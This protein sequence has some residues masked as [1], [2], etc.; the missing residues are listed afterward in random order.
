MLQISYVGDASCAVLHLQVGKLGLNFHCT[1][2]ENSPSGHNDLT[3]DT[4]EESLAEKEEC[5][6][7]VITSDS[8]CQETTKDSMLESGASATPSDKANL[9]TQTEPA[10][11]NAILQ[12]TD[13]V[14]EVE[15]SVTED[16]EKASAE[17]E[18]VKR[19]CS[20]GDSEEPGSNSEAVICD[21]TVSPT[22]GSEDK[23]DGDGNIDTT[24]TTDNCATSKVTG[25]PVPP[26]P[27]YNWQDI[28]SGFM[29]ASSQLKLGEL[30]HDTK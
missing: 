18:S 28:T 3:S 16:I 12:D 25:P 13:K 8:T 14:E 1:A 20:A 4:Y 15:K 19:Q 24:V 7:T 21:K 6:L 27:Q 10:P 23:G 11:N 9:D 22:K 26:Q 5:E 30:L 17:E 29:G 2:M